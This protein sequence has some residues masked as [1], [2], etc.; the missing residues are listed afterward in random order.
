[1]T[2]FS[3]LIRLVYFSVAPF[4]LVVLAAVLPMTGVLINVVLMLIGFVMIEV[5]RPLAG[6]QR[7]AEFLLARQLAFEAYYREHPPRP[8]IYYVLAPL[9]LPYWLINRK[10]R[11]ELGL[12]RGISRV[13]LLGLVVASIVDYVNNWLP[14]IGFDKFLANAIALLF[15]QL[16]I[17][18]GFVIPLAVTLV[19]YRTA[20]RMRALW[21]LLGVAAVALALGM[22]GLHEIRGHLVPAEVKMRADA[23]SEAAPV[24]AL[25]A[26]DA[27][28]QSVWEDLRAGTLTMDSDGWLTGGSLER[29]QA[30]LAA[31]YRQ[32]EAQAFTFHVWPVDAP[33]HAILQ[34]W[35]RNSVDPVWRALDGSGAPLTDPAQVPRELWNAR[36]THMRGPAS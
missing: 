27:A 11:R 1:M 3:F 26:Q 19:T 5:L 10:A 17:L 8:F 24:A 9:L 36:P 21:I 35:R 6:R 18:L 25:A 30:R 14:E 31:F 20:G 15:L 33:S 32:D 13:G 4:I 7:A 22:V 2:A 29:A 12:Y 34:M 16:V 28:L 23:R